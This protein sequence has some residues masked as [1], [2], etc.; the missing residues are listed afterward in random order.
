MCKKMHINYMHINPRSESKP[1]CWHSNL[2]LA[3]IEKNFYLLY[4]NSINATENQE[5]SVRKNS[6]IKTLLSNI[7]VLI[8]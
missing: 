2:I 1:F 3:S 6:Q 8:K 5:S 7:C 4:K